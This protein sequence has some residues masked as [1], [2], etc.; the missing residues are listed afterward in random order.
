MA[1]VKILSTSKRTSRRV[2]AGNSRAIA[3]KKW[4]CN[5]GQS[6]H[7][8][9]TTG[10]PKTQCLIGLATKTAGAGDGNRTRVLSLGS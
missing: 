4:A 8:R 10:Q 3:G 2:S 7:M 6:R 1:R 5:R 9:D